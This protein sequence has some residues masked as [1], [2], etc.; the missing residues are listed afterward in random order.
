[1]GLKD[2]K[3]IFQKLNNKKDKAKKIKDGYFKDKKV[4]KYGR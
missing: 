2:L 3:V 1:L 4:K